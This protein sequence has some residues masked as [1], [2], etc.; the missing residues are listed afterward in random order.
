M[1]GGND[2]AEIVTVLDSNLPGFRDIAEAFM[3]WEDAGWHTT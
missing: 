1:A 3:N 2:K